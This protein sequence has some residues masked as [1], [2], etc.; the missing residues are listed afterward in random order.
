M[1][2]C[3][4]RHGGM[5]YGQMGDF[6]HALADLDSA[7][8]LASDY[9]RAYIFRGI[10]NSRRKENE[11]AAADFDAALKIDPRNIDG[12]VNRAALYA[13]DHHEDLAIDDLTTALPQMLDRDP[14]LLF[15]LLRL[16]LMF[17]AT[18]MLFTS[19]SRAWFAGKPPPQDGQ[20]L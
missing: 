9:A 14:V 12:L 7:V 15:V 2:H 3:F 1:V 10:T 18:Y 19:R 20:S 16:G 8:G 6:G 17:A 13:G 4:L 5:H 11:H